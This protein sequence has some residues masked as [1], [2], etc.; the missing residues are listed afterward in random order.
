MPTTEIVYDPFDPATIADPYP[1]YEWLR[2]ESPVHHLEQF[3]MWAISRYDDVLAALRKPDLFSSA[4]GMGA[5]MREGMTRSIQAALDASPDSA[6]KA[7]GVGDF[8]ILIA[9]DPPVHQKLRHLVAKPFGRAAIAAMRPRIEAICVEMVD[10]LIAAN[11]RGEADLVRDLAYP[12]PVTVIAEMLGIP[13]ERRAD[14]KRWSDATLLGANTAMSSGG[15]NT[16]ADAAAAEMNIYFE[17]VIR[18]RREDPGDDLISALV[19]AGADDGDHLTTAEILAFC[20]LLL[21]AGNETT[22]NLIANGAQALFANPR[23]AAALRADPSLIPAAIEE[24]LRYDGPVQVVLRMTTDD[25]ELRDVTI[26]GGALVLLLL[27]S[28]DR[29]RDHYADADTFSIVRNP[30]DHVGFGS[31]IHLCLGAPLARLEAQVAGELL[32]ARTRNMRPRGECTRSQ[33]FLI[34]GTLALPVEFDVV[35]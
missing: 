30:T 10:D 13:A 16:R 15:E 2:A 34:R 1:A 11:E 19:M 22:T 23:E 28:A 8:R 20:V 6:V 4:G 26:P 32:L 9:S 12:L 27:G 5:L 33:S 18:A 25:V 17:Q 7:E 29:D 35:A 3:G 21:V 31:S 24:T 14:F